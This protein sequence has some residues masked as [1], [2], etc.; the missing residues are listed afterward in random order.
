M[1]V[2][3]KEKSALLVLRH[4]ESDY[5]GVFPDINQKGETTVRNLAKNI[6]QLA[7]N[8]YPIVRL[9][10]GDSARARGTIDALAG[11]LNLNP[12]H[13]RI[14][15][16]L[17]ELHIKDVEK[18]L[19]AEKQNDPEGTYVWTLTSPYLEDVN[20]LT[21]GRRR[22]NERAGLFLQNHSAGL[23]KESQRSLTIA[24]TQLETMAFFAGSIFPGY[25]RFPIEDIDAPANG[26][27]LFIEFIDPN[28]LIVRSQF[29]GVRVQSRF[30]PKALMFR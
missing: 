22:V 10:S 26:E 17:N 11:E 25:N 8:Y 29:R 9:V 21:E 1:F 20:P 30:D 13:N 16:E 23:I 2:P 18:F 15:T 24:V 5:T 27:P 14:I 3:D 4:A 6:N 7:A 19:E 28:S 12:R